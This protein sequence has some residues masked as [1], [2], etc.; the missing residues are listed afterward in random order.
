ML[1]AVA[2]LR[3]PKIVG[4][5]AVTASMVACG[6]GTA[7]SQTSDCGPLPRSG[8]DSAEGWIGYIG[9]HGDDIG[10]LV[11]DGEGSVVEHRTEESMPTASAVK[12]VHLA[13]YARAVANGDLDPNESVPVSEWERWYLPGTDGDAHPRA[14]QRLGI[15]GPD[16]SATLEQMVSAMIQESD[17]AVPDYLRA[18]LGDDA[19]LAAAE[20]GGWADFEVPT[21]LGSTIAL[22]DPAVSGDALWPAAQR[23]ASDPVY[24]DEVTRLPVTDDFELANDRVDESGAHGTA[25]GLSALHRSIATGDFG[26]GS[27]TARA[28]LEWQPAPPGTEGLGFKGGN[29]PGVLTEA[30][31]MRRTDGTVANAVLFVDSLS[32]D[33]YTS[34]TT[35]FAHQQLL[36]QAMT[37]P[38]T[39]DQL[40]CAV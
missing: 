39:F 33:D 40:G 18:R 6:S 10:L 37:D 36:L 3:T 19:L 11:D 1:S 16:A 5:V 30:M 15:S 35:S 9:E 27:E 28:Q 2:R 4:V 13:A 34:A 24:R 12:V 8:V 21:M 7:E 32:L 23:Y 17:N 20:R 22:L 14:L 25:A 26:P 31:T 38:A 29:L